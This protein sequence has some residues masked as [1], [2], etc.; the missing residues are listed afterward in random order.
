[1]TELITLKQ[2]PIIEEQLKELSEKID[3]NVAAAMALAVTEDTVK[4]VK[5]VRTDL[6][7]DFD[8]LEEERKAVKR[9]VLEP[10][11]QFETVYKCLVSERYK[12]ADTV[13]KKKIDAVTDGLKKQREADLKAFFDELCVANHVEWLTWSRCPVPVTLSASKKG[14]QDAVT[15]F[16]CKVAEDLH[17]I[18]THE[19]KDE[20]TVEYKKSLRMA[21]AIDTVTE[22]HAALEREREQAEEREEA[23]RIETNTVKAVE[24]LA[25]PVVEQE[26]KPPDAGDP[27]M[28]LAFTVTDKLSKLKALKQFLIDGGYI[29]E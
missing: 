3:R 6:R 16:V 18:Q 13:L 25:P 9:A 2:L 15:S 11:N 27:V 19:H 20:I 24:A 12:T 22:R 5:A 14:L 28:Q 10:Y 1:M 8:Q 29:Y 17:C 23:N 26:R 4:V 7:K 21:D